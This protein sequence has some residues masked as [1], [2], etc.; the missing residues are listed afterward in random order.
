AA[1][2][3]RRFHL[4]D[5]MPALL[6]RAKKLT[7]MAPSAKKKKA[8][9]IGYE[10]TQLLQAFGLAGYQ[11]A[12]GLCRKYIPKSAPFT[13]PARAAAIWTLG[14]LHE[15]KL[16]KKLAGQLTSRL[17]DNN[18]MNPEAPPVKRFSAIAL[19]RMKAKG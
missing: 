1:T 16:D 7:Q 19:G 2:A 18:M 11:P 15:G 9:W 4:P 17:L 10:T 14:K 3:L 5:T 12:D 13:I 8:K 6:K